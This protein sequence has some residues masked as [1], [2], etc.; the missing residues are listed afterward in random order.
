MNRIYSSPQNNIAPSKSTIPVELAENFESEPDSPPEPLSPK[1]SPKRI[2][3]RS[4]PK[5]QT[6]RS[7]KAIGML[8]PIETE[9]MDTKPGSFIEEDQIRESKAPPD[10]KFK[11]DFNA[12]FVKNK[13]DFETGIARTSR[14]YIIEEMEEEA[15]QK[16][17]Q[18]NPN[19][20]RELRI[21][22]P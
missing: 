1:L 5:R 19:S 15:T 7:P 13:E 14:G 11:L 21:K 3:P 12:N 4:S 2:T 22:K 18:W 20:R 10:S 16:I 9:P 8:L 6:I 17:H